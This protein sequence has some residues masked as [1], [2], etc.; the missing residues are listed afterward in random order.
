MFLGSHV[1]QKAEKL[2]KAIIFTPQKNWVFGL[3]LRSLPDQIRF[4]DNVSREAHVLEAGRWSIGTH[5][6]EEDSPPQPPLPGSFQLTTSVEDGPVTK[7]RGDNF[8]RKG[9]P[10]NF[11]RGHLH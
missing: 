1:F 11:P 4:V 7:S 3:T 9:P 10:D 8:I 2:I 6:G 5:G